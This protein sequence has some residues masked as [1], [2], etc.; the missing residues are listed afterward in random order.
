MSYRIAFIGLGVMG[1]RM[2][3][4]MHVNDAFILQSG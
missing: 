2:L 1:Q 3:G 4:N